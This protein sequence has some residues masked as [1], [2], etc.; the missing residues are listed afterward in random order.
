MKYAI[1][2]FAGAILTFVIVADHYGRLITN[3]TISGILCRVHG[4]DGMIVG[5]WGE[6]KEVWC[7]DMLNAV[8]EQQLFDEMIDSLQGDDT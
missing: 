3:S 5:E 2:F 6:K 8:P 4:L 7:V 1:G